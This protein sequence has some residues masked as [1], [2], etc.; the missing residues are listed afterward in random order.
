V[1][2]EN[3][4]DEVD[5][6]IPVTTFPRRVPFLLL[7]SAF[8]FVWGLSACSPNAES[9]SWPVTTDGSSSET[10]TDLMPDTE[11]P[12]DST[13]TLDVDGRDT[14][15]AD[16][17]D[18]K[19]RETFA[20][21][22]LGRNCLCGIVG[23]RSEVVCEPDCPELEWSD[24][25]GGVRDLA[26]LSRTSCI[27]NGQ[28]ELRCRYDDGDG[29]SR[30]VSGSVEKIELAPFF[31]C[32]VRSDRTLECW[33][34]DI[35]DEHGASDPPSEEFRQVSL[36]DE[37][38]CGVLTKDRTIRCWGRDNFRTVSEVPEGSF[39]SVSG[40]QYT[41]CGVRRSGRVECWG[42]GTDPD[43]VEHQHIDYDQGVPPSGVRFRALAQGNGHT[44]GLTDGGGVRCWGAG[45]NPNPET[46]TGNTRGQSVDPPG[47]DYE[48]VLAA[49]TRTCALT[50]GGFVRCWGHDYDGHETFYPEDFR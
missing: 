29:P 7:A 11:E 25:S 23:D 28:D 35:E 33:M 18:A 44:C 3:T 42:M 24:V 9:D 32:A 37:R 10:A 19:P 47:D 30:P 14:S 36:V 5:V 20:E 4:S 31:G 21:I 48:M 45:E 15:P 46:W 38:G 43:E 39:R 41:V 34:N 40:G 49:G 26:V 50:A 2:I 22:A 6:E 16:T 17:V 1:K 27:V 13:S 12:S 8:A